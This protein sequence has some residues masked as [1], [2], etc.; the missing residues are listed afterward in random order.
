M[1]RFALGLGHVVTPRGRSLF[2]D[3]SVRHFGVAV[4]KTRDHGAVRPYALAS[5]GRYSWRGLDPL[6]LDPD[7]DARNAEARRSFV[8]ASLGG[9][10]LLRCHRRLSVDLEGR[11]H[12]SL[13]KVARPAFEGPAQHWN[14]VSIAAGVKVLW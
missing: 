13:D 7:F 10:L 11:W 2:Y 9:G 6:A 12:T 14:M 4:T 8:G 1:G 3:E 5:L